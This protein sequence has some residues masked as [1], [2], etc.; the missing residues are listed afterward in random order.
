MGGSR[1]VEDATVPRWRHREPTW[2]SRLLGAL[3]AAAVG[4]L[5]GAGVFGVGEESP[6][7]ATLSFTAFAA[8]FVL[9]IVTLIG[10]PA[11]AL[12]DRR[13]RGRPAAAI[14]GHGAVGAAAGA[15]LGVFLEDL[16]GALL[17][18]AVGATAAGVGAVLARRLVRG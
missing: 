13:L 7:L 12:I 2:G 9:P 3:G 4:I 11:S 10:V 14:V 6:L 15:A 16:V 5:L 8:L 18:G 17:F 1:P